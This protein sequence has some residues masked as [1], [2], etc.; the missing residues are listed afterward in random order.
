MLEEFK[1]VEGQT[2][3]DVCLNTYQSLDYLVKLARDNQ[4]A[5]LNYTCKTGDVFLFDPS[6][7]VNLGVLR[8]IKF[9]GTRYL[10]AESPDPVEYS[11]NY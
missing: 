3:T 2:L 5:D 11:L 1:A 10:T 9:K 7:V 8:D 6:L 4:V